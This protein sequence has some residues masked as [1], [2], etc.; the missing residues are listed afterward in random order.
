MNAVVS[1]CHF[2][3]I[4]G[5][6]VLLSTQPCR[7]LE[8]LKKTN[9]AFYGPRESL[10]PSSFSSTS[11]CDACQ[12]VSSNIYVSSDHSADTSYISSQYPWQPETD[13]LVRQACTRSLSCEVCPGK[14]GV[15]VFSDDVGQ[16][17]SQGSSVLS[18]TF[19]ICDS[20]ARGFHRWFS[21]IVLTRDRLLLL[22]WW[23]FLE[24]NISIFVSE[25]QRAASKVYETEQNTHPQRALRLSSAFC[26]DK[27][28]RSLPELTGLPQVF[29]QLHLWFAW[30]LQ[31]AAARLRET[32]PITD[33]AIP[34]GS[35]EEQEDGFIVVSA[36]KVLENSK[37]L[38]DNL[39]YSRCLMNTNGPSINSL[40]ELR[41]VLGPMNFASI[42][43]CLIVGRQVVV[44]GQPA[45]L[46]ASILFTLKVLLPRGCVHLVPYSSQYIP[47]SDCNMLGIDARAAVP[48]P[49]PHVVRLE[50][51]PPADCDSSLKSHNDINH[52]TFHLKWPGQLPSKWPTFL[53]KLDRAMQSELLNESTLM[54]QIRALG[55]EALNTA[56]VLHHLDIQ[57]KKDSRDPR[58]KTAFLQAMGVNPADSDVLAFWSK[59]SLDQTILV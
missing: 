14:E 44:R 20:L 27:S 40:R 53:T 57:E 58:D 26:A 50:V 15:L 5:P 35:L 3:E 34:F 19:L 11:G 41:S 1:L 52:F 29:A 25:L 33:L 23:P 24:K 4:H 55:M 18:Y 59:Q 6:S 31:N 43:Y 36:T 38:I 42:V 22:N 9:Q 49:S 12:S 39:V 48:Q 13:K 37:S 47:L 51:L 16:G 54:L 46:I 17:T 10:Q 30:L 21:I 28:S 2:C 7:S 45:G 32:L 56:R 8:Q